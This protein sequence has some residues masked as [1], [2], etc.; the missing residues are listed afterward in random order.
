M[1]WGEFFTVQCHHLEKSLLD[2]SQGRKKI[3]LYTLLCTILNYQV[4]SLTDS[5]NHE[6]QS[7]LINNTEKEGVKYYATYTFPHQEGGS[8]IMQ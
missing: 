7:K 5:V 2:G 3:T 6:N 8:S 4:R 1:G